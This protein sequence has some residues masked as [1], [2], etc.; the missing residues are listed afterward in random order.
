MGSLENP[1]FRV[2]GWGVVV[3]VTKKTLYRVELPKT[4][5]LGQFADL[6]EGV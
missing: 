2:G 4:G 3:L 5:G 1:I 6:R